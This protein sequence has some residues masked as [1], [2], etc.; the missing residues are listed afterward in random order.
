MECQNR[1]VDMWIF[2]WCSGVIGGWEYSQ[3][4]L[5]LGYPPESTTGISSWVYYW[6]I[7]L[8][9]LLGYLNWVYYWDIKLSVLL[10]FSAGSG[11]RILNWVYYQDFELGLP[12]WF[13]TKLTIMI[14]NW[15]T[16]GISDWIYYW[17]FQLGLPL[18]FWTGSTIRDV[19]LSLL[20]GFET[21]FTVR[22]FNWG[23]C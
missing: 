23:Y 5:L 6:D 4:G 14:L 13:W 18:E 1:F 21:E 3:M 9:L 8:S 7:R 16:I 12:L 17:D 10:S 2:G 11:I 20:F 19:K 15:V 22:I